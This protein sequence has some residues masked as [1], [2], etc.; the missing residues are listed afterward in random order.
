M[1][2]PMLFA[3]LEQKKKNKIPLVS[4]TAQRYRNST[5]HGKQNQFS[6]YRKSNAFSLSSR[7]GRSYLTI[8]II[9][10]F[11]LSSFLLWGGGRLYLTA[12]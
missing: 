10:A 4:M 11:F 9:K 7:G 1:I 12:L 2:F 5:I 3:S 6:N 8:A